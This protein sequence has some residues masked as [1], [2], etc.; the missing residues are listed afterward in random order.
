MRTRFLLL[1]E[2]RTGSTLLIRELD[3]R[4][5]EIRV[6]YEP[7][8]P[9]N[10]GESCFED[11]ARSFYGQDAGEPIVGYKVF[12]P[13][14]TQQQLTTLIELE[15]T[16]VMILRRRNHLRRHVSEQIAL[17][18]R[19]WRADTLKG[20]VEQIP[21]DRRAISVDTTE[22]QRRMQ[23]S[24]ENF[25]EFERLSAGRP[26]IEL[27]YEDL[28]DDLDGELRRVAAFLGAGEPAHEHPPSLHRQNPEP[29]RALII[30]F[31]EVDAF[32]RDLGLERFLE[33]DDAE[34][35]LG[36]DSSDSVPTSQES[37]QL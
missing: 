30:N 3:Q 34:S 26:R 31:D 36:S 19:Q 12:G 1:S 8:N 23:V 17:R 33:L 37:T 27:W 6:G 29:L 5:P 25:E 21:L 9:V 32:L 11:I 13:H 2:P 22:L 35:H 28:I 20:P 15:G 7:L 18:T 24:R 14:V 16:R 10:R 4:W